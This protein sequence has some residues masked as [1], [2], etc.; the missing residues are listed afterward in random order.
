[1][2]RK[3]GGVRLAAVQHNLA[4]VLKSTDRP[5]ALQLFQQALAS[6]GELLE[7]RPDDASL[8]DAATGYA[9]SLG[10]TL[11]EA[12]RDGDALAAFATGRRHAARL[13]ELGEAGPGPLRKHALL[14]Y[15]EG[16]LAA[17]LGDLAA[18]ETRLHEAVELGRR[19]VAMAPA[20]PRAHA[21][22]RRHRVRLAQV[23]ELAR[24]AAALPC[25]QEAV[26]SLDELP[27]DVARRLADDDQA[28]FDEV[29]AQRALAACLLA[30]ADLAGAERALARARAREFP[31][32]ANLASGVE[33]FLLRTTTARLAEQ[34]GDLRLARTELV[35]ACELARTLAEP[36]QKSRLHCRRVLAVPPSVQALAETLGIADRSALATLAQRAQERLD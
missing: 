31:P 19:L 28:G 25:W 16:T 6:L 24:G 32:E 27:P 20:D 4:S 23:V 10:G 7:R 34:R 26:D 29:L 14:S 33:S 12:A 36:I 21:Q 17:E 3:H 18:A 1:M 8:L 22:L 11:A 13:L 35:G 15:N 30:G 9:T 2:T 5:R